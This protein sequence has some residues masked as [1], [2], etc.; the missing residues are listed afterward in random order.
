MFI[1]SVIRKVPLFSNE[2]MCHWYC[3]NIF[4][5]LF[6]YF[7]SRNSYNSYFP[8]YPK[9]VVGWR[10]DSPFQSDWK[11]FNP[12]CNHG[13]RTKE[14]FGGWVH[15][16][17]HWLI[18]LPIDT[19]EYRRWNSSALVTREGEILAPTPTPVIMVIILAFHVKKN[20]ILVILQEIQTTFYRRY[21][22]IRWK[23]TSTISRKIIPNHL[24]NYFEM[25]KLIMIFKHCG[26]GS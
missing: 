4:P 24:S 22:T 8:I 16:Y 14:I 26:I 18:I 2:C 17:C 21:N 10:P 6:L 12:N 13:C 19:L 20:S 15:K 5:F 11:L 9:P 3:I 7:Y 25:P 23:L 1:W